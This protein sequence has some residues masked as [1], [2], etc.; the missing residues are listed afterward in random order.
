VLTNE[1]FIIE[2]ASINRLTACTIAQSEV[3]SL[4]HEIRDNSVELGAF[5]MKL[6]ATFTGAFLASAQTSEV[7]ST[8]GSLG[9]Q[10]NFDSAS[11]L[12]PNLYF[13]VD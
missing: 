8:F 7:F 5:K 9:I 12:V 11:F 1:V 10:I 13:Q 6:Y 4:S 2:L 3:T